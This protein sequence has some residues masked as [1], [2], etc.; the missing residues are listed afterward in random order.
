M[1]TLTTY[2]AYTLGDLKQQIG[3]D[4]NL[5]AIIETLEDN[6][7]MMDAK[8]IEANDTFSNRALQR[9]SYPAGQWRQLN[10]G[11]SA[12]ASKT[13]PITDTI[14][15]LESRSVIDATL[16][17]VAPN[18][19]EYRSRMAMSFVRGLSDS[20]ASC[21]V[22]GNTNSDPEK[23]MGLAPRMGSLAATT[24]VRGAGGTGSDV[25]SIYIVQ[26][27]VDQVF[28]FY[29]KGSKIGIDHSYSTPMGAP[30]YTVDPASSTKEFLCYK[31]HFQWHV[32]LQV[33]NPRCIARYANIESSGSY[34]FN[35]DDLILLLNR[36]WKRG[37][38]AV[39]YVA[40]DMKSY[41]EIALKD[42]NNVNFTANQGEGLAGEQVLRF[43]GCPIRVLENVLFTETAIS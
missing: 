15:M 6:D 20:L 27:G 25:T 36:M 8:F 4:G 42:K 11:V 43:R 7:L 29:P 34:M 33:A 19:N 23:F 39:M 13:V 10:A 41:M 9:T 14:G 37:K 32:G 18:P 40:P 3:P 21:F 22:Y 1:S 5:M 24:N 35:E 2:A 26:W 28:F 16:V 17:K 30:E 31:D 12:E 38:G